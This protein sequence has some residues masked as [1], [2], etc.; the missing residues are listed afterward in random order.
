MRLALLK[1]YTYTRFARVLNMHKMMPSKKKVELGAG[2]VEGARLFSV[3]IVPFIRFA[4]WFL[5]V[6][7]IKIIIFFFF[8][9]MRVDTK[10]L[11]SA[12]KKRNI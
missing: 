9:F 3:L 4:A 2:A 8:N 12:D 11:N 6:N 10:S 1:D 7:A 5:F